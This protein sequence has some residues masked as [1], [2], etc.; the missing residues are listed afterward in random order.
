MKFTKI[1]DNVQNALVDILSRY[2]LVH[3]IVSAVND[4]GGRSLLIGGAVRDLLLGIPIKDLDIEVHGVSLDTLESILK[5]CGTV[6]LVG[7][8]YGVLRVH[9]LD[10]DWSI[11]RADAPGRKPEVTID[12]TMQIQEA[13]LRRDLTMNAMGIDLV[14]FE[15]IDPFNGKKDLEHK[16]LRTPSAQRFIEDPLRFY[17]VMQFVSRFQMQPDQELEDICKKMDISRVSVERIDEEFKK[18]L[19]KSE[20]PS[21]GIRWL[22]YIGRLSEVLPELAATVGVQ[23]EERWHPEGDVFEHTMQSLD[24]ASALEFADDQEKLIVMYAAICHDLGKATTTVFQDGVYH[25]Y[26]HEGAGV[27]AAQ[28]MMPR[29]TR[30]KEIIE[31]IGT[32]VKY[33]MV[34]IQLVESNAGEASYKRMARKLS[35][36]ATLKMLGFLS[37]CDQRGRNPAKNKPLTH[38]INEIDIFLER[39]AQASVLHQAEK[40][41]LHGRDIMDVIEPGPYMGKILDEAYEIQLQEGITDKE[42]L[43]SR[44]LKK[45]E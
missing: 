34:P 28:K 37:L 25:S 7:K 31:A 29:I 36:H 16:V 39:A 41:V 44:V 5:Q 21:L 22:Q 17:R 1:D 24:A 18:L 38:S 11:P 4:Q 13:F 10:I 23:Q 2:P 3:K 12:P 35:P 26:G 15:L 20:R 42:T 27:I 19:L 32:L 8:A 43:R 6:S 14:S 33:H 45:K 9:G 40:P 30:N